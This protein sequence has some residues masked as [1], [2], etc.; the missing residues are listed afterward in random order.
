MSNIILSN[1]GLGNFDIGILLIV[2]IVL[3]IALI[4]VVIYQINLTKKLKDKYSRFMQ[5][6]RPRSMETQ[7]QEMIKTLN[8]LSNTSLNHEKEIQ[9]LF[10][11]Q[12]SNFQKMGLIKYD[13][14]K[15][16]GGKLSY[17]LA[18]LDE[19]DNGFIINS[20]HTSTGCYS[21]TKR[22]R[23]GNC[24]IDLSPEEREA[25]NRAKLCG[26]TKSADD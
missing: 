16:M 2:L 3:V 8:E 20:V 25:L 23:N 17:G 26:G 12:E 22:I 24:N 4:V 9:E 13:A 15:E 7:I 6:S 1:T 14:Y 11:K 10:V 5:G 19:K 18:I 21:Y